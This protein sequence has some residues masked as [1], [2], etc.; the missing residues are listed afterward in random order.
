MNIKKH[1]PNTVTLGNLFCG[2][3][4]IVNAF[5]GNLVWAAVFV[6]FA[7][8]LDFFDG[9]TARL[10]KVA[11][12]IGKDLDS[13]ADMVTFGI[14]PSMIMFQL[15]KHGND[16]YRL[17]AMQLDN[18]SET[19]F[20]PYVAFVIAIFSCIRLAKF[21]NDTRQTGSFIG[22]PTPANAMVICSIPLIA[23]D[24]CGSNTFIEMM[25]NPNVLC[26]ISVV[27]SFLL[28]AELPLFALK[29]KNFGWADNKVKY[30]FLLV[31]VILIVV[32]KFVAIPL[33]ILL[34]ILISIVNNIFSKK[35]V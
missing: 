23:Q 7:L 25:L 5:E 15:I 2:C 30:L 18:I 27:M 31:S 34:Y 11:S 9:F 21:N 16:I 14:V 26:I 28:V 17:S 13:L 1:I 3:L 35:Q 24:T 4:A 33:V 19:G 22:L 8:I 32:L 29:F 12:P 10:L 20:M 6:G